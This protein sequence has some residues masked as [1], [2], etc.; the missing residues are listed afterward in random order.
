MR[1]IH[2]ARPIWE[3][4]AALWRPKYTFPPSPPKESSLS[5]NVYQSHVNI[6]RL[7]NFA[8]KFFWSNICIASKTLHR[9][10]KKIIISLVAALLITK[11]A[12]IWQS[13]GDLGIH[14]LEPW[15]KVFWSDPRQWVQDLNWNLQEQRSLKCLENWPVE[16]P[17][18][19]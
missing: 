16:S 19:H 4:F 11:H 1:W 18:R 13:Y 9:F 12:S 14:C 10:K 3:L 2:S 7:P 17:H 15:N 8:G 5:W 6:S